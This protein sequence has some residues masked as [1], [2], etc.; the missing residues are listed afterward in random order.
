MRTVEHYKHG[1]PRLAA[2]VNLDKN[3]AVLKRFDYLHS[4]V[5]LEHQA[6]LNELEERLNECDD[7][8]T[9]QM[10]LSSCRQDTNQTR[11]QLLTEIQSALESYG[12]HNF[13]AT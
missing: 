4:R 7:A 9:V 1:Y 6:L 11:R 5:L 13:R 2:F 12:N 3:F 8:D 10:H